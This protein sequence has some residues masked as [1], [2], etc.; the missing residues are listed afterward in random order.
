[1]LQGKLLDPE[2]RLKA[3]AMA[4]DISYPSLAS[5]AAAASK[6]AEHFRRFGFVDGQAFWE[7]MVKIMV[8]M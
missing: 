4:G 1:M 8:T 2:F 7:T 6:A 3:A 5:Q